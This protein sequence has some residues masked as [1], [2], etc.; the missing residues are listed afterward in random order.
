FYHP[1]KPEDIQN[2][3]GRDFFH[4]PGEEYWQKIDAEVILSEGNE[5]KWKTV[6]HMLDTSRDPLLKE[7]QVWT[8][9]QRGDKYFLDLEWSGE[10]LTDI[11]INQFEYGGL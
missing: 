10:A 11:T 2:K 3:I 1:D 5:V 7:T 6:Y 4:H 8:F 9:T